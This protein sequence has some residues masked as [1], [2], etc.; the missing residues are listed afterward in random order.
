MCAVL[1]RM[2]QEG[3][4]CRGGGPTQRR[5]RWGC[6]PGVPRC[7]QACRAVPAGR[8]V[9]GVTGGVLLGLLCSAARHARCAWHASFAEVT[10]IR[11]HAVQLV[12]I[13]Q[14]AGCPKRAVGAAQVRI[15]L[16]ISRYPGLPDRC[17]RLKPNQSGGSQ[18]QSDNSGTYV[19]PLAL[20]RVLCSAAQGM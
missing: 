12:G 19:H 7:R 20:S 10:Y 8:D 3:R 5:H 15:P 1:S 14:R 17:T 16:R 9:L 11:L 13:P 18:L 2:G 4:S 6:V